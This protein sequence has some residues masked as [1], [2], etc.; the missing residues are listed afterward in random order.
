[1][2]DNTIQGKRSPEYLVEMSEYL[3]ALANPVR[4]QI[5]SSLES[6]SMELK[7]IATITRTSYENIRK[8][9]DKLLLAGLVRKDAGMSSETMTG[10]HPVWKYSLAPGGM[11]QIITNLSMFSKVPLTITHADLADQLSSIRKEISS[12]FGVTSPCLYLTSGPDEGKI[13]SLSG[14]K[15][16]LGRIDPSDASYSQKQKNIVMLS[17]DYKSVSRISRPHA[18][19]YHKASWEIEDSGS[20][21]GTFINTEPIPPN[22]RREISDGDIIILGTGNMSAR[23]LFIAE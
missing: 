16:S 9:M 2:T 12:Q 3:N 7:E 8:H 14:E 20:T 10:I 17:P 21:S 13:F 15:I 18:R 5:L 19:V 22:T 6:R 11:E 4:L 1:M 23:F